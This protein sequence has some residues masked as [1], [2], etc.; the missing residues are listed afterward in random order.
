MLPKQEEKLSLSSKEAT[1][2]VVSRI[3]T[4]DGGNIEIMDFGR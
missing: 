4:Q 2:K 3:Q 1:R